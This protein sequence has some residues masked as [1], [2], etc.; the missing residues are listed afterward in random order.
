MSD[1]SRHAQLLAIALAF[2]CAQTSAFAA[3]RIV[4]LA[5]NLTELAFAAGAGNR[6]IGTV[7]YSDYPQQAKAIP[8]IGD[9]FR[10]DYERI[11]ALQPDAIL[12]WE[13]GTPHATV[14][15]LRALRLTVTTVSTQR[16]ADIG[17]AVRDIGRIAGTTEVASAEADRFEQ[18]I[19]SLR[20]EYGGRAPVTVF[21]Q[22]NDQPLYTINGTQIMS[23]VVGLCGGVNVFA[24]LNELAPQIGVEAVIAADPQVI[25]STGPADAPAFLQWR[26]WPQIRAVHANNLYAL[27]PDNLAR[28]TTR[29][30]SGARDM[31]RTLQTARE[32]MK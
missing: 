21:L 19:D 5:P 14:E 9:A 24:A 10:V 16:L 25:I 31:C 1:V 28:S 13:P 15:R 20:K 8:R 22:I 2:I 11:L 3:S 32:R 4:S 27:P 29:L 17:K 7:E 6:V 12:A 18:I 30:A 26:R 23:E